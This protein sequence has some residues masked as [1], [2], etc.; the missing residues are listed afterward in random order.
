MLTALNEGRN[1]CR[2]LELVASLVISDHYFSVLV[3]SIVG[4]YEKFGAKGL[5][6]AD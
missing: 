2:S 4:G 5:G 3:A 6:P 1:A